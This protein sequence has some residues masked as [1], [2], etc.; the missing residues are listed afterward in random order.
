MGIYWAAVDRARGEYFEP[1]GSYANKYPG[2]CH[3]SNPFPGMVVMMNCMAC[4]FQM[5]NDMMEPCYCNGD[6][7]NITEEVYQRY[8]DLF[9]DKE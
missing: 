4:E 9:K 3:P 8:Q 2:V 7:K 6:L 1:P 5:E